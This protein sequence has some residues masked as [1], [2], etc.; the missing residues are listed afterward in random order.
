MK[1][2]RYGIVVIAVIGLLNGLQARAQ[3]DGEVKAWAKKS[4]VIVASVKTYEE[5]QAKAKEASTKLN[6]RLDLRGLSPD[7]KTG[8]TFSKKIC[9]EEWGSD[10]CYLPR[11]R[12]DDGKYV[13]IEYS[14][15]FKHFAKGY[16]VVII[17]NGDEKSPVV[18]DAHKVAKKKGY[19]DAY[20]KSDEV[21]LGCMH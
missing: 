18:I 17:A 21:Y 12:Y 9:D 3:E 14:S 15:A 20:I 10:P 8:L 2:A 4:F 6:F 19:S 16:Y 11:G 1:T 7:K 13:S 5:A